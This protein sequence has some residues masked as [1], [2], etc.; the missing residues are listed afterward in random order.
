MAQGYLQALGDAAFADAGAAALRSFLAAPGRLT[1]SIA[2]AEPGPVTGLLL[3]VLASP[4]DLVSAL[5][6]KIEAQ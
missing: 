1:L 2:P 5:G 3:M 6:L 4:G